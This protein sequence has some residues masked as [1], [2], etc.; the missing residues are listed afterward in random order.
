MKIEIT[1]EELSALIRRQLNH[2][3]ILREGAETDHLEA[4]IDPTLSKIEHCFKHTANRY[5]N[6]DGQTYF[7]PFHSGQYCI[8]LYF[9]SRT[10]FLNDPDYRTLSDRVYFLNKALNAIDLFYEVELPD[11]FALDHP[12]GTVLGRAQY[13]KFFTFNQNNTVGENKGIYPRIGEN[14]YMAS[15][16]KLIGDSTVGNNVMLSANSYV[17]DA[18]IPSCSIV[19]GS[20]PHLIIKTRDAGYFTGS[21]V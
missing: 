12:V 5:Y 16:S 10:I 6:Q 19:F 18:D 9:L 17:K 13:G 7:N 11:V 1:R 3:F 2:L 21:F 4:S 8:F 15:G 20:S 14:V